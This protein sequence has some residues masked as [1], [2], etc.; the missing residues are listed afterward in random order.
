MKLALL[1]ALA[2]LSASA[3]AQEAPAPGQQPPAPEK[4]ICRMVE[5]TGSIL[6]RRKY[7][8]TRAEWDKFSDYT[9]NRAGRALD[10][11]ALGPNGSLNKD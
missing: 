2:A 10:Q 6:L 9:Q 4:K 1:V 7:C 5:Q 3:S 8:L 11:R